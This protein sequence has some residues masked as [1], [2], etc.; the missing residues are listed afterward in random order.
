MKNQMKRNSLGS[1]LVLS[2]ILLGGCNLKEETQSETPNFLLIYTDEMQ[3]SDLGCYGGEIP[4]PN[5]D[6]LAAEG[7]M[8][9]NAYTV[10]S[11]CTP[12]RYSVL[13]GQFPGRCSAPSFAEENPLDEP[14]NIA[15]NAWITT[16]KKTLPRILSENG[17]VTGMAGK[18]H[19]GKIAKDVILPSFQTDENLDN[20]ETE[21]KLIEQ[22]AIHQSLIE[23]QGGFDDARSVVWGNYDGQKIKALNFHNFPWMTKGA[24][25]FLEN[26]KSGEKPFFLYFAPTAVHGPNHV[27]DLKR[28]VTYTLGGRDRSLH[29][30]NIDV[31]K[32]QEELSNVEPKTRHRYAGVAQT[33]HSVGLILEKLNELKLADNTVIIFMS[34]HNIEPGKA[35]SYEK[36]IHV[37][38]IVYWPG[39]TNGAISDA[40]VQNTDIYPTILEAA[41]ISKSSEHILDGV[42]MLS[43]INDPLQSTRKFIFSENGYT[44]SVSNGTYKYIALR[45]PESLIKK[46]KSGKIDFAPSYV[47]AWPQDHSAIAMKGFPSYFDQD[48]VYNIKNDPYEQDNLFKDISESDELKEL[49]AALKTHLASFEHPFNLEQIPFLETDTYRKLYEK[50]MEF[51]LL[52]IPWLSR[53]HGFINWPPEK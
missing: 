53:D 31:P 38:L 2:L 30:L 46:M 36:G 20:L 44:R 35:T 24:L 21:K 6:K 17:F 32:I 18:W 1:I 48:Q 34:D 12:S 9:T 8:F 13:T 5:I 47:K 10:A 15:W 26:Q 43:V 23:K 3:F 50:N 7:T 25:S 39:K 19:I 49:Q 28:D 16:D 45:Y 33:D 52:S 29:N 41:G 22:Q 37:P 40:L 42:S 14:Y 51:D 27:Q 4:T 11:M